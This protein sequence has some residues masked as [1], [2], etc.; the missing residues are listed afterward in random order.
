M[1]LHG[2]RYEPCGLAHKIAMR[3]GALPVVR[4]T[5]GLADTVREGENGFV[6]AAPTG[7]DLLAAIGRCLETC[8]HQ[9]ERWEAMR[10]RAMRGD[11]GWERPALEYL[12]LYGSALMETGRSPG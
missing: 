7:E 4:R 6:F 1:L 3:Y 5:G 12:R 11:Y 8:A 9:P 2:S 10:G